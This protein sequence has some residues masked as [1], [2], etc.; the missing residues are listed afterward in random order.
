MKQGSFMES[1]SPLL[2]YGMVTYTVSNTE[3]KPSFTDSGMGCLIICCKIVASDYKI[4]CESF[5]L[6]SLQ[7]HAVMICN[8][9]CSNATPSINMCKC[10]RTPIQMVIC[11][12]K[13]ERSARCGQSCLLLPGVGSTNVV[14]SGGTLSNTSRLYACTTA[15]RGQGFT[16]MYVHIH[17]SAYIRCA[18]RCDAYIVC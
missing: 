14:G 3:T 12:K 2:A 10:M 4:M 7:V 11:V 9:P 15:P 1:M 16:S 6:A 13:C 5:R 8:F 18:H 17:T